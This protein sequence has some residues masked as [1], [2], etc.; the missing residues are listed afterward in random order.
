MKQIFTMWTSQ[1]RCCNRSTLIDLYCSEGNMA[2]YLSIARAT[3][4]TWQYGGFTMLEKSLLNW[5][6]SLKPA[7]SLSTKR[8][9][10]EVIFIFLMSFCHLFTSR[11]HTECKYSSHVCMR[12]L[13]WLM[14]SCLEVIFRLNS[15]QTTF[16]PSRT[17]PYQ[18]TSHQF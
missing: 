5:A 12:D 4:L 10:G 3:A 16:Q 7:G 14:T 15:R 13:T 2:K 6:R 9:W 11:P 1:Y 17:E 18:R 8:T